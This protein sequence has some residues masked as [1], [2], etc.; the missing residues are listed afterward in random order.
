MEIE[1]RILCVDGDGDWCTLFT[2]FA[3]R[4]S[5]V[6][7]SASNG[8]KALQKLRAGGHSA[9]VT[10][11]HLDDMTGFEFCRRFRS[12]DPHTP[13]MFYSSNDTVDAINEA[14]AAGSHGYL[15]KHDEIERVFETIRR[16]V[17]GPRRSQG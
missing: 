9:V 3:K 7:D 5:F 14:A 13:L 6:V 8:E 1:Q 16:F 15:F 2:L 10:D 12:F 11:I 4:D 17:R